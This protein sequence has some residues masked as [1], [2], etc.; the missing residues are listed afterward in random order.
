MGLCALASLFAVSVASAGGESSAGA[1]DYRTQDAWFRSADPGAT[2]RACYEVRK[3]FGVPS[4]RLA[5]MI[6]E[7]F[8]LWDEYPKKKKLIGPEKVFIAGKIE[9]KAKCRGNEDL[10]FYFGVDRPEIRRTKARYRHPFAFVEMTAGGSSAQPLWGKG[11]VWVVEPYGFGRFNAPAWSTAEASLA[12]LLLHEIGHI[13]G[14]GHVDGTVMTPDI[15]RYLEADTSFYRTGPSFLAKYSRID[16]ER[17]LLT[18]PF[19]IE[20]YEV[21]SQEVDVKKSFAVLMGREPTG[22][23]SV[24]FERLSSP[25]GD[26]KLRLKDGKSSASLRVR[27][28]AKVAEFADGAPCFAGLYGKTYRHA[29]VSFHAYLSTSGGEEIPIAL[30][31]NLEGRK[32]SIRRL[33]RFGEAPLFLSGQ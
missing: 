5:E 20:T 15:G 25:P 32:V 24:V 11:Y 13:F 22:E 3:G 26:S 6:R 31:Y 4:V 33:D 21:N 28:V 19:C 7:A 12:A 10:A 8:R 30:N 1:D 2:V 23:A 18:C 27:T 29:G 9:L 17:E 14:T 16:A